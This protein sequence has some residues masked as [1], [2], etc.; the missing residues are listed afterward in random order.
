[1]KKTDLICCP[2]N[3]ENLISDVQ[4][5][6]DLKLYLSIF[7]LLDRYAAQITNDPISAGFSDLIKR[8]SCSQANDLETSRFTCP[9]TGRSVFKDNDGASVTDAKPLLTEQVTGRIGLAVVNVFCDDHSSGFSE[10]EDVQPPCD[11]RPGA[12][13]DDGP[14]H[15]Q[16]VQTF[17]K[18][19]CARDL[20]RITAELSRYSALS[21]TDI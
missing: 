10:L 1:M 15:V 11:Q 2:K 20:D 5:I 14:W 7:E 17:K 3:S 16:V 6:G 21:L 13:C 18:L 19:S 4:G 9:N 12:A 8:V